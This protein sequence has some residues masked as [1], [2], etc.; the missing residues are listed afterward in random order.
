[1]NMATKICKFYHINFFFFWAVINQEIGICIF[2]CSMLCISPKKEKKKKKSSMLWSFPISIRETYYIPREHCSFLSHE[3]W[4]L[5]WDP[6]VGF[7]SHVRQGSNALG[8]YNNFPSI[9]DEVSWY[10]LCQVQYDGEARHSIM[11]VMCFVPCHTPK[12][13]RYMTTMRTKKKKSPYKCAR[14]Q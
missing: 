1:M 4:A 11:L 2:L 10:D 5:W 6:R 14:P 3:G 13:H 12:P 7:A 9:R 8:V